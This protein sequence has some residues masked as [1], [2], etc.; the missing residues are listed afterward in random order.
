MSKLFYPEELVD[1][2]NQDSRTLGLP[3]ESVSIVIKKVLE[4][5]LKW[6]ENRDIITE[7]DLERVVSSE[8]DKY[9]PDLAF[10]YRNRNKMI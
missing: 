7:N 5:V 4:S 10:L 8:L 2:L 3:E 1:S 9:S 6:L